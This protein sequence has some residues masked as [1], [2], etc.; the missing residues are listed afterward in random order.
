MRRPRSQKDTTT[1]AFG[2]ML[3]DSNATTSNVR[4]M[5]VEASS[6]KQALMK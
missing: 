5:Y 2:N 1:G 6:R 3:Q 4:I